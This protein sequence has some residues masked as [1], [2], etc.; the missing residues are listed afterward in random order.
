MSGFEGNPKNPKILNLDSKMTS[1]IHKFVCK[2][3]SFK[4]SSQVR[5]NRHKNS[6]H[7][8]NIDT[9]EDSNKPLITKEG[10]L[11]RLSLTVKKEIV[12][13][14]HKI[15]FNEDNIMVIDY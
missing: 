8:T 9:I 2:V 3:S 1:D 7:V 4:T 15:R 10:Q 5:F 11:T 14:P 6:R 12:M 13:N